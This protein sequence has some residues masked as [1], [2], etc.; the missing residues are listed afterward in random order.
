MYDNTR[1]LELVKLAKQGDA[2]ALERLICENGGLI[3]AVAL[4]FQGR[5]QDTDDLVQIG[6]IGM[7]KAVRGFDESFG[8]AFSTYAVHMVTGELK[9]FLR[10]DGLIKVSRDIKRRG[11]ILYR[12]GEEFAAKNGRD[13]TVSELCKICDMSY[14]DAVCAME[15]MTPAVSLQEKLG[16]DDSS[17]FE[18]LVGFIP[19]S[20]LIFSRFLPTILQFPYSF[21]VFSCFSLRYIILYRNYIINAY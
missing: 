18:E 6:T 5:G 3:K 13:A 14:E 7:M 1:N 21:C 4:R 11:Y 2:D 16:D 9:R 19:L 20:F 8:T 15:A 17:S 10:D 12:A